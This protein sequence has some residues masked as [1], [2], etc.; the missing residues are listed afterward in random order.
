MQFGMID[1][2]VLSV[3]VLV[4]ASLTAAGLAAQSP[5][6]GGYTNSPYTTGTGSN[7]YMDTVVIRR[8]TTTLL[9]NANTG[10]SA[11]PYNPFYGSIAPA[12]LIPGVAHQIDITV[13]P[14]WSQGMTVFIDYNND[15]DFVDSNETVGYTPVISSGGTGTVTFTPATGFGGVL[16]MRIRCIYY[17]A[18]HGH[19]ERD[20]R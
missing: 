15:G 7:D 20:I 11:S 2:G 3:L 5:P 13:S 10:P 12:N 9:T 17:T 14:S 4:F 19:P 1:R 18:G 16:R 6:Y 8:G